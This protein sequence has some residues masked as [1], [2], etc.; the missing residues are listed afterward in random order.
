ML[1]G[2]LLTHQT[3]SLR[4]AQAHIRPRSTAQKNR[5]PLRLAVV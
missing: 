1:L 5:E 4:L 2:A 3:I